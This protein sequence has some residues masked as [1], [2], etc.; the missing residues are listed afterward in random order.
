VQPPR[1]D[2]RRPLGKGPLPVEDGE[3][4][5][6]VLVEIDPHRRA[7]ADAAAREPPA[8]VPRELPD[9]I[10][11][12]GVAPPLLERPDLAA[13]AGVPLRGVRAPVEVGQE[14]HA[15]GFDHLPV[16]REVVL[17]HPFE[18]A[19]VVECQGTVSVS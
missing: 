12:G 5:A 6:R 17:E 2:G 19:A 7:V 4:E 1:R 8:V 13:L 15:V 9:P 18:D 3:E 11:R 14:S 16:D 10:L